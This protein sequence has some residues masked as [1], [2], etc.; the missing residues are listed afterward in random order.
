[1]RDADRIVGLLSAAGIDDVYLL[2]NRIRAD[3]VKKGDMLGIEDM[4]EVLGLDLIGIVPEDEQLIRSTNIGEPLIVS[5]KSKAAA[6]FRNITKRILGNNVPMLD[7]EA[8]TFGE[9]LK[10]LFSK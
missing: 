6:A 4:L 5:D 2:I 1:M 8:D 7:I 9:K 10:K 3:M